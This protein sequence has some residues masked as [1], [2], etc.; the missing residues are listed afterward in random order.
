MTILT[1]EQIEAYEESLRAKAEKNPLVEQ[2][3]QELYPWAH[4][5][6]P[7]LDNKYKGGILESWS[8][9]RSGG[10]GGFIYDDDRWREGSWINTSYVVNIVYDEE[11]EEGYLETRNTIYGLGKKWENPDVTI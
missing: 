1:Q 3:F 9:N 4:L 2:A 5:I 8:I 10:V 6:P 7:E 11:K